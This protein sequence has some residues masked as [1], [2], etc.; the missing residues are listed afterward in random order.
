MAQKTKNPSFR[1]LIDRFTDELT[2]AIAAQVEQQVAAA[3]SHLRA[4]APRSDGRRSGRVCPVPGCGKPGAG[5]RN[6]WFC[7]DHARRL[8]AYEQKGILE[9][10]R[11]LIA[12]GKTPASSPTQRIVRLPARTPRPRRSLDMSCRVEGCTNRSRGPRAGYICD[13]HRAELSPEQQEA[14]RK[15][16]NARRKGQALPAQEQPKA[17]PSAVPPIV[18]KAEP[19]EA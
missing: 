13:P 17:P 15:I 18:R 16:W 6:R 1:A 11:R 8:S 5:P 3:L 12:E 9:R 10:N 19:A 7:K 4:A 2:A 14:A